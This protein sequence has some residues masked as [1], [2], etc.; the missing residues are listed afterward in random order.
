M[1]FQVVEGGQ[2]RVENT[3]PA[4]TAE[5]CRRAPCKADDALCSTIVAVG[6]NSRLVPAFSFRTRKHDLVRCETG[7]AHIEK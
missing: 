6:L 7:K 3:F 4:E 2:F 1:G 5:V